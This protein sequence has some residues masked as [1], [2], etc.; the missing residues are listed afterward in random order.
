MYVNVCIADVQC[1]YGYIHFKK[2]TDIIELCTYIDVSFWFQLFVLP[3][4]L[5]CREG[6][7]AA[8]W[9]TYSSSSTLVYSASAFSLLTTPSPSLSGWAGG[10]S[11]NLRSSCRLLPADGGAATAAPA[12]AA[13]AAAP[14]PAL[15]RR[16]PRPQCRP[17]PWALFQCPSWSSNRRFTI[18][19]LGQPLAPWTPLMSV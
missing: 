2:C 17:R 16:R 10:W 7:A 4:W 9:H 5:A 12:G 14:G 11:S 8:R 18:L 15:R 3:G 19:V 13:A 6:L 1:T